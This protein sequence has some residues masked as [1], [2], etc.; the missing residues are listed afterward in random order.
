MLLPINDSRYLR[1]GA[2]YD[3]PDSLAFVRPNRSSVD[4]LESRAQE[5][6]PANCYL[7]RN[8][9]VHVVPFRGEYSQTHRDQEALF[10]AELQVCHDTFLHQ[11]IVNGHRLTYDGRSHDYLK[12]A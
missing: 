5:I 11:P 12:N 1:D 10:L 8:G 7:L 9:S 6:Y 3:M 2:S 4:N